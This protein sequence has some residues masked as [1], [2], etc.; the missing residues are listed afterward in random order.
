MINTSWIAKLSGLTAVVVLGTTLAMAG[1]NNSTAVANPQMVT[2]TVSCA[3][4][5]NH[6]Y[7]CKRFDT[8]Q[9]CTLSCVQ[10]GSQ[11][12]LVVGDTSYPLQ[13]EHQ[14]LAQFAGGKATVSGELIAPENEIQVVSVTKPGS[15]PETGI[16][17]PGAMANPTR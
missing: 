6:L 14:V 9:S 11:Y 17:Q 8:Q 16:Q 3:A 4:R 2:G 7:T 15:M 1:Q 5:I 13:G 12:V 10:A